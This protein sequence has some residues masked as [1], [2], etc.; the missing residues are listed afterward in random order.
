MAAAG[1]QA[2][3]SPSV[4]YKWVDMI[5]GVLVRTS[6]GAMRR[7][8]SVEQNTW[9]G[10]HKL[11]KQGPGAGEVFKSFFRER[12]TELVEGLK[13]A[14]TE[15]DVDR[16]SDWVSEQIKAGLGNVRPDQL[17]SY[18]K[19]RKPVDLYFA[20]LV[21]MAAELETVRSRLAALLFLPLDFWILSEP[22]LFSD[23]ELY[24]CGLNR[25]SSYQS[26]RAKATYRELQGSLLPER[27]RPVSA[28]PALSPDLFRP[29]LERPLQTK[30][31]QFVRDKLLS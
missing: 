9:R 14:R 7:S 24:R 20:A 3:L 25:A 13:E 16:L 17:Q 29:Y 1:E 31:A 30:R 22:S 12:Q 11:N 15:D 6:T 21:A 5:D 28:G 18:N 19:V 23:T 26:V 2:Y 27:Q 4:I 8:W 10:F